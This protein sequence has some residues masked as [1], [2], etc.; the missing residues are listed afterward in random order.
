MPTTSRRHRCSSPAPTGCGVRVHGP[1]DQATGITVGTLPHS[2][3]ARPDQRFNGTVTRTGHA[4]ERDSRMLPVEIELDN[5]DGQLASGVY[6]TVHFDL[7]R[8][9]GVTLVPAEALNYEADGLSV[10]TVSTA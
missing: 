5:P 6:A 3:P 10:E 2:L 4:L 7:P 8:T 9:H 1:Q